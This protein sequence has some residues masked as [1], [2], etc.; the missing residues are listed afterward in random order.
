MILLNI[1]NVKNDIPK[2]YQCKKMVL[3]NFTNVLL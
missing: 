2:H 1:I 3:L